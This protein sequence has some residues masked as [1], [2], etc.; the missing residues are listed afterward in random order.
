MSSFF[1]SLASKAQNA[2]EQSPISGQV[3]QLQSK[4]QQQHQSDPEQPSA[5]QAAAQGG[6][7]AKSQVLGNITH[8]FRNLQ[9]Q[10]A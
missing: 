8:Q 5:N 9:M 1:S 6:I 10:Y 4:L 7:G 2:Y 3:S